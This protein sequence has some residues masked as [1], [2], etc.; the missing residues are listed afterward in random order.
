MEK[1]SANDAPPSRSAGGQVRWRKQGADVPDGAGMPVAIWSAEGRSGMNLATLTLMQG[2]LFDIALQSSTYLQ[3]LR[4]AP[5]AERPVCSDEPQ[6][7]DVA[8][9]SHCAHVELLERRLSM[10]LRALERIDKGHFGWCEG[11]GREIDRVQLFVDP[12]RAT[13]VGCDRL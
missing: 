8:R 10:A 4:R 13:C 1:A 12:N 5:D 7:S 9:R 6:W 3:R 2:R 11:C